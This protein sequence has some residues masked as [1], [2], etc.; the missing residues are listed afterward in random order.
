MLFSQAYNSFSSDLILC[1]KSNS[2][3]PN[4]TAP[5]DQPDQDLNC[6]HFMIKNINLTHCILVDSSTVVYWRSPFVILGVSDL[7]CYV[8]SI[9]DGKSY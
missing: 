2:V 6:A 1:L 3:D 4:Q 9:F 5:E 8:Y 7:F